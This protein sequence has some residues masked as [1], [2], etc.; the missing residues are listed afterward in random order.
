MNE[1]NYKKR[2]DFQEKIISRK[3]EQIEVLKLEIESLK[4]KL[5]E[6]DEL[7][8][9]V[10][11]LRNELT[12]NVKQVKKYK[13]EYKILIQDLK[14]MKEIINQTVY[15]GRWKLIKFLIK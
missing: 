4:L 2:L 8:N 13:E 5:E 7:I 14:K 11:P 12:E 6:K 10:T 9:S 15:K 3:N 1:K